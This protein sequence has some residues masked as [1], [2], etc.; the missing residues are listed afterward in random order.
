MIV[1]VHFDL[2]QQPVIFVCLCWIYLYIFIYFFRRK[3][4]QHHDTWYKAT[5]QNDTNPSNNKIRHS[6]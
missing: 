6:A 1:S 2:F 4:I 5:Q 3:D